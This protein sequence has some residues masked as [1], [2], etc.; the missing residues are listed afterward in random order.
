MI[1]RSIEITAIMEFIDFV[2]GFDIKLMEEGDDYIGD[3]ERHITTYV[4]ITERGLDA[5][6]KAFLEDR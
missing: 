6:I 4:E 1:D 2:K 3:D 5:L